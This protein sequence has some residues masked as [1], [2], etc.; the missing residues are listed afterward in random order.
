MQGR[1]HQAILGDLNT[2]AHGVARLS[3][4]YCCDQMRFWTIGRTEA[5]FW[6]H[7]VFSVPDPDFL[8]ENDGRRTGASSLSLRL[9]PHPFR[10]FLRTLHNH[11]STKS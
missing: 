2:M 4:L 8:P 9:P 11:C 10:P 7:N 3:P 1:Y 5:H 6:H